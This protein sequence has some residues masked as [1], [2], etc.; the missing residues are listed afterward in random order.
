MCVCMCVGDC[1]CAHVYSRYN[2]LTFQEGTVSISAA[3][4]A[5][6]PHLLLPC[7]LCISLSVPK[8]LVNH[9]HSVWGVWLQVCVCVYVCVM[10]VY[11]YMTLPP[12]SCG[13]RGQG[14]MGNRVTGYIISSVPC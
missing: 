10:C 2:V 4:A 7:S 8:V 5:V 14:N 13:N 1:V 9:C 6:L 3:V 12:S 11:A